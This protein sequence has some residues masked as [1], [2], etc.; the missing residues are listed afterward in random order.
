LPDWDVGGLYS[1]RGWS[2]RFNVA[3]VLAFR[4]GTIHVAIYKEQF[5]V[6]PRSLDPVSLSFGS[7]NDEIF[8]TMH[9]PLQASLFAAYEPEL[10]QHEAVTEDDLR[11]Y[12]TYLEYHPDGEAGAFGL[13]AEKIH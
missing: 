9:T 1:I 11:G 3:K 13:D 10:I 12:R 8:G 4:G 2:D 7:S 6:R 5:S